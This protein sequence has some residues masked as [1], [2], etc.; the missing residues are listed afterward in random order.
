MSA[1][2]SLLGLK[3]MDVLREHSNRNHGLSQQEIVELLEDKYATEVD[4]K[5]V[6]RNLKLLLEY[7]NGRHIGYETVKRMQNGKEN[8]IRTNFYYKSDFEIGEI[9]KMNNE[10]SIYDR[11][12]KDYI[13]LTEPTMNRLVHGHNDKGYIIIT[14]AKSENKEKPNDRERKALISDLKKFGYSYV[15]VFGGYK[16]EGQGKASLEESFVVFPYDIATEKYDCSD[17]FRM[18]LINLGKLHGQESIL[19]KEDGKN[20]VCI[21]CDT[22]EPYEEDDGF[23]DANFDHADDEYFAALKKH[24]DISLNGKTRGFKNGNPQRFTFEAYITEQPHQ[25]M[26]AHRRHNLNE[27]VIPGY[28]GE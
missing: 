12:G 28:K 8:V 15:P 16:E 25:I 1:N 9:E 2:N 4:R 21:R 18:I 10:N 20:P 19:V 5:T 14:A 24:R 22:G 27:F 23:S 26:S 17:H 3:I 7:D 13:P 6:G 11:Y